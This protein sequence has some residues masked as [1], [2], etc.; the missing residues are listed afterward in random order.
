M[1]TEDDRLSSLSD[2]LIIKILSY[3]KTKQAIKTSILSSRWKNI[4][5]SIPHL[6]LSTDDVTSLTSTDDV[7]S[8]TT[9][10]EF[11][12]VLSSHNNE[13]EL[14][15][16]K[17]SVRGEFRQEFV[18]TVIKYA[19]SHNVQKMTIICLDEKRNEIPLSLF[20]SQ[21]LKDLTLIGCARYWS[22]LYKNKS[23]WDLPALT[24]LHLENVV[25]SHG[26]R[27]E[28]GGLFS[29]CP[30]L[31]NLTLSNCTINDYN[32]SSIRYS[33]LSNLTVDKGLYSVANVVAPYLK[34]LTIV[35]CR[36]D[37]L[38]YAPELSSLMYK[39]L[40]YRHLFAHGL[41]SLEKVDFYLS[42][43]DEADGPDTVNIL[44]QFRNVKN[45]TLG[46]EI[47]EL[48]SF[49][50]VVSDLPS[51]FAK[52]T[53]V[54]IYP[55]NEKGEKNVKIPTQVE[56]F[57]LDASPSAT[58]SIYSR[59]EVKA[60]R[61]ATSAQRIMAKL[62]GLLEWEKID[63]EMNMNEQGETQI[64]KGQHVK[65]KISQIRR[66]WTDLFGQINEDN[67]KID[68]ILSMLDQIEV[69]VQGLPTSKKDSIQ[70]QFS[71]L[72]AEANSV[73]KLIL[74][75]MKIKCVGKVSAFMNLL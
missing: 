9:L 66:C 47:V 21:S 27:D 48:D 69:L 19:F 40:F 65:K 45:L 50:D 26:N 44:Q 56:N 75:R 29:K 14:K 22:Q 6:D 35:N 36:C 70:A 57:L 73:M 60:L 33:E 20:I 61:D 72:R 10:D 24:T 25:E 67:V 32:L 63:C 58:L 34:N 18:K 55:G 64:N 54:K 43:L 15:S 62:E 31:K 39:N 11:N 7:T 4:W 46:L 49:V 37:L 17:L 51:P 59:E 71:S 52:L 42:Y 8:L 74:D 3:N 23:S 53:S 38:I 41:S 12:R 28:Y 13:I 16:V 5:K 68:D 1:N 2:D 30:N